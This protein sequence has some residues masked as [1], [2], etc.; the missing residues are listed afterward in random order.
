M[1][2]RPIGRD[3]ARASIQGS[4]GP[5]GEAE[6]AMCARACFWLRAVGQEEV[7]FQ[8]VT[9]QQALSWVFLK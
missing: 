4:G 2:R 6:G 3:P 7:S 8:Q 1:R 9:Q 5:A